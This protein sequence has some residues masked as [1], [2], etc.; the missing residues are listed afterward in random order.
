[1]TPHEFPSKM[2]LPFQVSNL[3]VADEIYSENAKIYKFKCQSRTLL[4]YESKVMYKSAI[5]A[6]NAKTKGI[7]ISLFDAPHP[8]LN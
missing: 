7:N 1:M 4:S 3:D 8:L 6:L 2:N 5:Q